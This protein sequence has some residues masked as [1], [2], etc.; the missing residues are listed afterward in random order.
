VKVVERNS[1]DIC[2]ILCGQWNGGFSF[3][4]VAEESDLA[5]GF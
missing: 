3:R 2:D 1:K 5:C 4:E